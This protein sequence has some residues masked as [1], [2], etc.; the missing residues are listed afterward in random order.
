LENCE[1]LPTLDVTPEV[2]LNPDHG[3]GIKE[4]KSSRDSRVKYRNSEVN[5]ARAEEST[6]HKCRPDIETLS[7]LC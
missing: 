3:S 5:A 4:T 2:A 6:G 1:Y 7:C